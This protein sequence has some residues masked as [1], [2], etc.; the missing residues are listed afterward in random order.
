[1]CVRTLYL[2]DCYNY[3]LL[4]C[5]CMF[6]TE[7]TSGRPDKAAKRLLF[8]RFFRVHSKYILKRFIIFIIMT[9]NLYCT[10]Y[11]LCPSLLC[12]NALIF[13]LY[14]SHHF[15]SHSLYHFMGFT[16]VFLC[17]VCIMLWRRMCQTV[18]FCAVFDILVWLLVVGL[19]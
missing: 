15:C 16:S 5:D 14:A 4:L 12:A 13:F 7:R 10:L 11:H 17:L 1:M 18:F 6:V 2:F 19:F 8:M 9:Q 3:S